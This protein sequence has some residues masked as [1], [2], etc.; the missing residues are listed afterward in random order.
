M[1]STATVRADESTMDRERL[2]RLAALTIEAWPHAVFLQSPEGTVLSANAAARVAMGM[3]GEDLRGRTRHDP[4]WTLLDEDGNTLEPDRFP[5]FIAGTT[6]R[7][8]RDRLVGVVSG[9]AEV[10]WIRIDAIP[11]WDEGRVEAVAVHLRN[12]TDQTRADIALRRTEQR[13][14]RARRAGGVGLWEWDPVMRTLTVDDGFVAVLG[15]HRPATLEQWIDEVHPEDRPAMRA[16]LFA[17]GANGD[18]ALHLRFR[19][20]DGER[21]WFRLRS[22]LLTPVDAADGGRLAGTVVDT[23]ELCLAT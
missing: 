3:D 11:L 18:A 23:T 7:A 10:R 2:E 14:E 12:V 6:G 1:L 15:G 17:G 13:L 20:T 16:R 5:G 9:S 22:E 4:L 21:R 8:V 19:D